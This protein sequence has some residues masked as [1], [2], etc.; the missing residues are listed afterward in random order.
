MKLYSEDVQLSC[1][2]KLYPP[3]QQSLTVKL[4]RHAVKGS[5]TGLFI[6]ASLLE[7]CCSVCIKS[8]AFVA[9]LLAAELE[10]LRRPVFNPPVHNSLKLRKGACVWCEH[11]LSCPCAGC[12][13]DLPNVSGKANVSHVYLKVAHAATQL[14]LLIVFDL[15]V[16]VKLSSSELTAAAKA[17]A[18]GQSHP[19]GKLQSAAV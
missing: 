10:A 1:T 16:F 15:A 11:N 14:L 7:R 6:N 3:V 9:L 4:F 13:V 12:Y 17:V 5:C 19:N 18:A 2:V 8:F